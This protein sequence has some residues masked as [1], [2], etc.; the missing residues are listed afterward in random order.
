MVGGERQT[1]TVEHDGEGFPAMAEEGLVGGEGHTAMVEHDR[2]GFPTTAE[3]EG[4]AGVAASTPHSAL[5]IISELT[6][7]PNI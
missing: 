2:E 7:T 4:H 6:Y 1:V 5:R 3:E